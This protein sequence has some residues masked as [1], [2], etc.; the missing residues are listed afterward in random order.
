MSLQILRCCI[1]ILL[2]GTRFE[3]VLLRRNTDPCILSTLRVEASGMGQPVITYHPSMSFPVAS[4]AVASEP[5]L[6]WHHDPGL[7]YLVITIATFVRPSQPLYRE[8][9]TNGSWLQD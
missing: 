3:Y 1:T 9:R 8:T 2:K 7:G 6:R 4:K 5:E